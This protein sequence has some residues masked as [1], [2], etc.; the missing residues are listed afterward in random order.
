MAGSMVSIG[1]AEWEAQQKELDD[2][3]HKVANLE[4]GRA[5]DTDFIQR[6]LVASKRDA[7]Q[8]EMQKCEIRRMDSLLTA[9]RIERDEVTKNHHA[10]IEECRAL[11]KSL[12]ASQKESLSLLAQLEEKD[13]ALH[14]SAVLHS[15][16]LREAAELREEREKLRGYL[17]DHQSDSNR[18][19][20]EIRQQRDRN[21]A[22]VLVLEKE[23]SRAEN[24]KRAYQAM[25]DAQA[26]IITE[27][28]IFGFG[29]QKAPEDMKDANETKR[30]T[31][32]GAEIKGEAMQSGT[33]VHLGST[34]ASAANPFRHLGE[35]PAPAP[36]H[37]QAALRDAIGH[38]DNR[39]PI[40]I[41][42][43]LAR[44]LLGDIGPTKGRPYADTRW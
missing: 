42:K 38:N 21:N 17:T 34:P 39:D 40:V 23:L 3:R 6:N 15:R 30:V 14:E 2:L 16:A 20:D 8:I 36:I 29:A 28:G 33:P 9:A 31:S 32:E 22:R 25:N 11:S 35:T 12:Q 4:A 7:E 5:A 19:I 10:R 43:G 44:Y 37:G 1:A 13:A 24:V 18:R 27:A 41:S 26:R